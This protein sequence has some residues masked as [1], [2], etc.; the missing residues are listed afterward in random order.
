MKS[1]DEIRQA[2]ITK[3]LDGYPLAL[4]PDQVA[5]ILGITRRT[6]DKLLHDGKIKYFA[7]DPEAERKQKR[8]A[9]CD[10][11]AYMTANIQDK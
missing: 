2:E 10:L 1:M 5:E 9:Q 6:V 3:L 11:I 8:V 4:D 7:I